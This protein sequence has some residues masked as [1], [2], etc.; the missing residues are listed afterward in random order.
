M[1][2]DSSPLVAV[3]GLGV[4]IPATEAAGRALAGL[5][6]VGDVL[7]ADGLDGSTVSGLVRVQPSDHDF[8]TSLARY[9]TQHAGL[10]RGLIVYDSSSGTDGTTVQDLYTRSLRDDFQSMLHGV[11]AYDALSFQGKSVPSDSDHD[12]FSQLVSNICGVHP[13]LVL[14]AGRLVDLTDFLAALEHR[15]CKP[16]GKITVLTGG[17]DLGSLNTPAIRRQLVAG[18]VSVVYSSATDAVDWLADPSSAPRHFG[19]FAD[20]FR[21][22][23]LPA[24]DIN[25][26]YGLAM[27]DSVVT[28]TEAIRNAYQGSTLPTATGTLQQLSNLVNHQTVPAASGDLSFA[29]QNHGNPGGKPLPVLSIPPAGS[30]PIATC[31][32]DKPG[33][34]Y[35]TP[36]N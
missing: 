7:T 26:G 15:E 25:D 34:A 8:V 11:L 20:E 16:L 21:S 12:M 29:Y 2:N 24:T 18:S 30:A 32:S 19:Q 31:A 17:T 4:S 13:N 33:Y 23:K 5:P 10:S 14:Y 35:C 6:M 28:A 9:L 27:Y 22:T 1:R 36:V 3:V